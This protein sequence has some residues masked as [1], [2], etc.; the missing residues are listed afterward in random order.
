L[1]ILVDRELGVFLTRFAAGI[2]YFNVKIEMRQ[3]DN[4]SFFCLRI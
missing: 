3:D 1:V 2:F 4:I